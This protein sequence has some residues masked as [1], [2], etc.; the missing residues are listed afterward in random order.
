[1]PLARCRAC[2]GGC[3]PSAPL[4][5]KSLS[6]FAQPLTF[7]VASPA[8]SRRLQPSRQ[9]ALARISTSSEQAPNQLR[10]EPLDRLGQ[11]CAFAPRIRGNDAHNPERL[12]SYRS[13]LMTQSAVAPRS[14]VA[15]RNEVSA[16][17]FTRLSPRGPV[18]DPS[19]A[20]ELGQIPILESCDFE[21]S[22]TRDA[23]GQLMHPTLSKTSTRTPRGYRLTQGLSMRPS[24]S[25]RGPRFGR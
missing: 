11:G 20:T 22:L 21:P 19:V 25:R 23:S 7:S 8:P 18:K 1:M 2:G 15:A 24:A 13:Q 4:G 10:H 16:H 17:P 6:R 12:G 5:W 3:R 14:D 9:L